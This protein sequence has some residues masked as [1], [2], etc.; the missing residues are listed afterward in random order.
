[1]TGIYNSGSV[2]RYAGSTYNNWVSG[3]QSGSGMLDGLAG[4]A[5]SRNNGMLDG[6][7]G[8]APS[9]NGGMLDGVPNSYGGTTSTK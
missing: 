4:S 5:P 8:G 2:L 3:S 1:M 7:A 9:R 6:L